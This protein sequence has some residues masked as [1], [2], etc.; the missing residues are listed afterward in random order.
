M[1]GAKLWKIQTV[2]QKQLGSFEMCCVIRMENNIWIDLVTNEKVFR[3]GDEEINILHAKQRRKVG[4][5]G[6]IWCRSCF[7]KHVI[8]GKVEVKGKR[9]RRRKLLNDLK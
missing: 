6:H 4:W 8:E 3:T 5:V 1:F 2:D 9:G 7:P